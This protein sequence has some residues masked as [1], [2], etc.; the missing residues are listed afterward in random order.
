MRR[1]RGVQASAT[2][3]KFGCTPPP[4]RFLAAYGWEAGELDRQGLTHQDAE[5]TPGCAVFGSSGGLL[6]ELHLHAATSLRGILLVRRMLERTTRA[7][8]G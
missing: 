4:A 6:I 7:G 5:G 1:S 2:A 8:V 3:I